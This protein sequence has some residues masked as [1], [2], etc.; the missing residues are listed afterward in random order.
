[1]IG[2]YFCSKL[3]YQIT[4][5]EPLSNVLQ[6]LRM[7][8]DETVEVLYREKVQVNLED[9]KELLDKLYAFTGNKPM[10]RLIVITKNSSLDLQARLHLQEENKARKDSIIAEAVVVTS[11]A[12]KMTT[13]FYLKFIKDIYPSRF[14]TDIDKAREWLNNY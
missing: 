9:M 7:M 5:M 8:N 3:I 12:Q 4:E 6:S 14:F 10:K 11:L 1:M 2:A 13:N